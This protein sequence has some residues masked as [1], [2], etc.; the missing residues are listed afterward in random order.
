MPWLWPWP[1]R[2]TIWPAQIGWECIDCAN[3]YWQNRYWQICSHCGQS[4]PWWEWP[5]PHDVQW[6]A[7]HVVEAPQRLSPERQ[8]WLAREN[9]AG[10][11][12]WQRPSPAHATES[13][14]SGGGGQAPPASGGGGEA[15]LENPWADPPPPAHAT[16]S[17]AS[18]EGGQAPPDRPLN[19]WVDYPPEDDIPGPPMR[20]DSV[21]EGSHADPDAT[22]RLIDYLPELA[23]KQMSCTEGLA[24]HQ[25]RL[26]KL[27]EDLQYCMLQILSLALLNQVIEWAC[28]QGHRHTTLPNALEEAEGRALIT[29]ADARWIRHI[30]RMGNRAKHEPAH[31]AR[32]RSPH[33]R[34]RRR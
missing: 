31:S 16:A 7:P 28:G 24:Y 29:H 17:S 10:G 19:P 6:L 9:V 27:H 23:A 18:G 32:S 15:P 14:A 22:Y 26:P 30:N 8:E 2:M 1:R 13:S 33:S 25:V 4:R 12:I 5:A 34:G 3:R 21:P 20:W 11:V